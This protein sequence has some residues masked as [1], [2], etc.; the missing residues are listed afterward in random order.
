MWQTAALVLI[1][2][3]L[4]LLGLSGALS[5]L[6]NS[7]LSPV[8]VAQRW[9]SERYMTMV[10]FL[11]APRDLVSMQSQ[12]ESL[13]SQNAKL[14]TRVI[15]LEQQLREAQVLYALLDFARAR[16]QNQYV[17]AA[18][19]GRD[20]SPFLHYIFID[21][22]SDD[23]IRHGMPVVTESGL[24][25]RVDAVTARAARVQLI[26]DP[27]SSINVHLQSSNADV[28]LS[29]SLTG[30]V[31]L[32]MVPQDTDLA[33]GELVLTSGLGGTYPADVVVG[34]VVSVRKF[35]TDLFQSASIQ[36]VVDFANLRAVLII[37]NFRPADIAPLVP[38]SGP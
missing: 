38:T 29:G 31:N 7:S 15:E 32:D 20:P 3:G 17:A 1:T 33:P 36:P 10:Q 8:V 18:V 21:H 19:I 34:Q 24:V 23:G 27:G 6:L 9:V 16:P 37:V 26:S 30:D 2:G 35:Q 5:R 14:Q 28:M 22:G 25:G 12:V 13:Q 11:T 4:I